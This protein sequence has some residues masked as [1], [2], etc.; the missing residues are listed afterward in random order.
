[1][2]LHS[3]YA[4]VPNGIRELYRKLRDKWGVAGSKLNSMEG[5]LLTLMDQEAAR[6]FLENKRSRRKAS[7]AQV[8]AFDDQILHS[9]NFTTGCLS[10]GHE[11]SAQRAFSKTIELRSPFSDRRLIEFALQMPIEAKLSI[12]WYKY[13]LRQAV[14]GMLPENVRWRRELWQHPGWRFNE[15]LISE[16]RQQFLE[17]L[18]FGPSSVLQNRWF[19]AAKVNRALREYNRSM[20]FIV[21]YNLLVLSVLVK[22]LKAR[23]CMAESFQCFP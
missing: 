10:F 5:S 12:P 23:P 15:T 14:A 2:V 3:L 17:E 13:V 11:M 19:D 6:E 21:G 22:W 1:M 20:D 8:G 18:S 7:L 9:R 16:A 4:S